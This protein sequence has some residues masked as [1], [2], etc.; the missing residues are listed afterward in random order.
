MKFLSDFNDLCLE[1][2]ET[3]FGTPAAD[4]LGNFEDIEKITLGFMVYWYGSY[5]IENMNAQYKTSLK[6]VL[7]EFL[8]KCDI[9]KDKPSLEFC[10][11]AKQYSK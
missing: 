11:N 1:Y 3:S 2:I 6:L 5:P 8:K 10:K 9:E 4:L 7:K